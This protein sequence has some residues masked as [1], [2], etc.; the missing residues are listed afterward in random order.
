MS[1]LCENNGSRGML[2]E[3]LDHQITVLG[4]EYTN[5]PYLAYAMLVHALH[6]SLRM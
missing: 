6:D 1:V 4:L 3:Q 5:K 2:V